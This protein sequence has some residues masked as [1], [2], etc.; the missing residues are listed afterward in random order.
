VDPDVKL[1]VD[2]VNVLLANL[3]VVVDLD[4]VV[5]DNLVE[6]VNPVD[7]LLASLVVV[8]VFDV[9]VFASLV[10]VVVFDVVVFAG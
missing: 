4:V 2:P 9:E 3:A 10:V 6:N 8:V 7:V 1:V 5:L